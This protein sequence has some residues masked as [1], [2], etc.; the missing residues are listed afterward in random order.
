MNLALALSDANRRMR[1]RSSPWALLP[2]VVLVPVLAFGG[3]G[4]LVAVLCVLPVFGAAAIAA[5]VLAFAGLA[6]RQWQ[7]AKS[8]K[9]CR[10]AARAAAATASA[11]RA[12]SK[13]IDSV[14]S[15]S[16]SAARQTVHTLRWTP[17]RPAALAG[18]GRAL[19]SL[20]L[21]PRLLAQRPAAAGACA[22][23]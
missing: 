8:L 23:D 16:L 3:W 5:R 12:A 11:K 19:A 10:R 18:A 9:A 13:L 22:G 15:L 4:G 20:S 1:M 2:F 17:P 6:W 7:A 14:I 21:T